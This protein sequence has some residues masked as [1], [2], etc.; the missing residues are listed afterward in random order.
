MKRFVG[1]MVG[2]IL[3]L[4]GFAQ[5]VT[6]G[7]QS[8][9]L[10]FKNSGVETKWIAGQKVNWETG[11]S[12]GASSRPGTTHCSAYVASLLK[13]QGIYILRPPKHPSEDLANFQFE[14][15][16]S[17]EGKKEGWRELKTP[18]EAQAAANEGRFV[19]AVVQNRDLAKPG[20]IAFVM[21]QDRSGTLDLADL[22]VA[23]AGHINGVGLPLLRGFEKHRAE[24]DAGGLRFFAHDRVSP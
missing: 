15:L 12:L 17:K 11:E 8:L 24:V 20:H 16:L 22:L 10:L 19:V 3:A 18:T 9:E 1:V 14:Y 7:G 2:V 6:P 13:Q 21:P 5:T 4:P 23:Q